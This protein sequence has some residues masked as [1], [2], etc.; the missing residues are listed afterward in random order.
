MVGCLSD[1]SN[2]KNHR[3]LMLA[4]AC[5][6]ACVLKICFRFM[7]DYA[8]FSFYSAGQGMC[9]G[10]YLPSYFHSVDIGTVGVF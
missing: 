5:I 7:D 8:L 4:I 10:A 1:I 9:M 3:C 2:L 6:L